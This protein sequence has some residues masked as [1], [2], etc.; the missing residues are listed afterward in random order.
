VI[1]HIIVLCGLRKEPIESHVTMHIIMFC[2][3]SKS[4]YE[5]VM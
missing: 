5:E 4:N 3:L 2:D 1:I